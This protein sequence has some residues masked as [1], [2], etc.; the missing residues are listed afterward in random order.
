MF[1]YG[2]KS[3]LCG[4]FIN[5]ISSWI[6]EENS[7]CKET[8][9][10]CKE[11]T[12]WCNE[13][14]MKS[15]IEENKVNIH[16]LSS[17]KNR[18]YISLFIHS[19]SILFIHNLTWFCILYVTEVGSVCKQ[20][21]VLCQKSGWAHNNISPTENSNWGHLQHAG[22]LFCFLK[23]SCHCTDRG[24]TWAGKLNRTEVIWWWFFFSLAKGCFVSNNLE[25]TNNVSTFSNHPLG[26]YLSC[27]SLAWSF[28]TQSVT[29]SYKNSLWDTTFSASNQ[30][31]SV[32]DFL[33]KW[34]SGPGVILSSIFR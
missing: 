26:A 31:P 2:E 15:S 30:Q 6:L 14:K 4:Y 29:T 3:T 11:C 23:R 17:D 24:I 22:T 8:A 19:V 16:Y 34:P 28:S 33:A 5:Y 12:Y 9:K 25:N 1:F 18:L 32:I 20:P 10:S 27:N 7:A 13:T 21:L